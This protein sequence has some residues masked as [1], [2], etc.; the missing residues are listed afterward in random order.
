MAIVTLSRA[1]SWTTQTQW[2]TTIQDCFAAWWNAAVENLVIDSSCSFIG[3]T[4]GALSVSVN[5]SLTVISTTNKATVSGFNIAGGFVGEV[6][7]HEQK[8]TLSFNESV[9]E[10][11]VNGNGIFVGGFVGLISDEVNTIISKCTN[12]GNVTG[13]GN[14]A[15]GFIGL[16]GAGT[17]LLIECI[18]NGHIQKFDSAGGFVGYT[19]GISVH[20]TISNCTNNGPV[21]GNT[22]VGGFIGMISS[23]IVSVKVNIINSANKATVS[24]E[25]DFGLWALLHESQSHEYF[26]LCSKQPQQR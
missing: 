5:G 17:V 7:T 22:G 25:R 24:A 20:M 14:N 6:P 12:N 19:Y 2:D 18:N 11:N 23:L 1:L 3:N 13:N 4:A 26:I 15:G 9:N 10:G 8:Y 21:T 16:V